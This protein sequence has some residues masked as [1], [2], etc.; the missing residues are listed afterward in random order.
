[1]RPRHYSY[2]PEAAATNS[3]SL[4]QAV[5]GAAALTQTGTYGANGFPSELAW[6]ITITSSADIS[7]VDITFV[8]LDAQLNQQTVTVAGPNTTTKDAGIYAS[9]IISVT[10]S[11][12]ASNISIGHTNVGYAPWKVIPS[13]GVSSTTGASIGI[14]GTANITLQTTFANIADNAIFAGTFDVFSHSY[15][16]ALT[17]SAFDTVDTREI[18]VRLKF[19][20]WSSGN[21]RLDLSVSAKG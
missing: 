5:V 1:M 16:A 2:T 12:S 4:S 19:N 21:V 18:G 3:I 6:N 8:Y 14:D 9:K 17:A 13:R 10:T 15:L 7:G 20:S 11:A